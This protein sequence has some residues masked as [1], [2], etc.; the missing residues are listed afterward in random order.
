M[1]RTPLRGTAALCAIGALAGAAEAAPRGTETPLSPAADLV[2]PALEQGEAI[3]GEV[4][5][6]F[7]R[8]ARGV[9]RA[10]ARRHAGVRVRRALRVE[11]VQLVTVNRGSSTREAIERLELDPAVRYAEPNRLRR[12]SA[13]V[14]NDPE[15]GQLWGL[16]NTGQSIDGIAGLP[17]SDIDA[18]EAWDL[19]TGGGTLVAIVDEGIAY[20]HPDLAPNMWRNPGE[21][22]GNGADD[23]GNGYVDDVHGIDTVDRDSD[24]RDFGGHGTHVAGTVAAAGDNGIG[25]AG[26]SWQAELMAVRALGP[27]GGTDAEV[28]EAFDYAG[29][30]GAR[31]VNASLG[32]PGASETLQQPITDHPNTLFVVAAGNGGEDG[33][34]D[35]NDGADPEFPCAYDDPNLIC[36][37]A[38]TESDELASF[39]N[40]GATTVD[41]GAPGTSVLSTAPDRGR[42]VFTDTFEAGDFADRWSP[43]TFPTGVPPEWSRDGGGAGAGDFSASDSPGTEYSDD[44]GTYMDLLTPLDLRDEH[45]CELRFDVTLDVLPGDS[46]VVYM[47]FDG[48]DFELLGSTS[49]EEGA[50]TG[51]EFVPASIDLPAAGEDSV[52]LSFG[53]ESDELGTADGASV[54]NIE[55]RCIQPEQGEGDLAFSSGTS[56][57]TPHVAGAA[58]LLF[59]RRPSLTVEQT[60]AILLSTGD[61]LAVL[62][63]GATVTGRRLNLDAALRH[64]LAAP[65]PPPDP[66]G[67]DPAPPT[68]P[69]GPH[70]APPT[71]TAPTTSGDPDP[72]PPAGTAP[73][74][75]GGAA[76]PVDT[77]ARIASTAKAV[78]KRARGGL[79]CTVTAQ[80][81]GTVKLRLGKGERTL[82]HGSGPIGRKIRLTRRVKRG[83]YRLRIA[84]TDA[85][86]GRRQTIV[87]TVRVR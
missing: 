36:V 5:V 76:A 25:V 8:A 38:T 12:P 6:G 71:G 78:C 44:A 50:W 63:G 37:A 19:A 33:I 60:K 3:P 17:D 58:A 68:D 21:I 79:T 83:R 87:R 56:M 29:D 30:M 35:D 53:I 9:E 75:P 81:A 74:T 14:P 28:A 73:T 18:P 51:G 32:G 31:V 62:D 1:F 55:V 57:A 10:A 46:F 13:T 11:G 7:R 16:H 86:S 42:V 85:A 66:G 84:I 61:A 65:D 54:D 59:S 52:I 23:D 45:G 72:A 43:V 77:L 39:S 4:L 27:N 15:F 48:V 40:F 70:P 80:G 34:G 82:A 69:G 67:P 64:P 20:D 2:R 47:S 49:P 24:P 41:L 22:A 26:V